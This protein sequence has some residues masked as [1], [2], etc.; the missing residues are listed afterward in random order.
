MI[1]SRRKSPRSRRQVQG[2]ALIEALVGILLFLFGLVALV[3]MQSNMTRAQGD[4]KFRA[5]AAALGSDVLAQMWADKP[6]LSQYN[7]SACASYAPCGQ[8]K[9][10]V[11]EKLPL[12]TAEVTAVG[13]TVTLTVTWSTK[14]EGT[15][16][17]AI[18]TS[19]SY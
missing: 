6:N 3:S 10:R 13:S 2:A 7:G 4:A 17:Y 11:A 16:A 15:H 14:A 19:I 5:D 9:A 1:T 8:W 12:G 18:A